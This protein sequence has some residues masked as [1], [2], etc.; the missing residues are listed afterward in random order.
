MSTEAPSTTSTVKR[1]A[2]GLGRE[3]LQDVAGGAAPEIDL[4]PVFLL[5]SRDQ[6]SHGLWGD[7]RIDGDASFLLG[8]R[9]QAGGAI[10]SCEMTGDGRGHGRRGRSRKEKGR[11]DGSNGEA[12]RE[13]AQHAKCAQRFWLSRMSL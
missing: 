7:R 8:A 12:R 1:P 2:A 9:D 3:A 11:D 5:E 10:G 6:R 4:H 13:S